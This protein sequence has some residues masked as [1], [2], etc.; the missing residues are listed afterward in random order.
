MKFLNYLSELTGRL[1]TYAVIF[2]VFLTFFQVMARYFLTPFVFFN[3]FLKIFNPIL[4]QELEWHLFGFIFLFG[5]AFTLKCDRHIRIDIF[6]QKL[7]QRRKINLNFW[8]FIFCL[9]PFISWVLFT[10]FAEALTNFWYGTSNPGGLPIWGFGRMLI[11]LGF[12]IFILEALRQLKLNFTRVNQ[13]SAK[14]LA[15]QQ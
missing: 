15:A 2:L 12:L 1:A 6:Y 3:P 14:N 4:L 5:L 13:E 9:L 8:G 7:T 11:P 10:G